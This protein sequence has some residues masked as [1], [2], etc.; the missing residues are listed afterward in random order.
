MNKKLIILMTSLVLFL[1]GCTSGGSSGTSGGSSGFNVDSYSGGD[2]AL[3]L[4]FAEGAPPERIRDQGRFPF[5]V[6]ILLEN[7][8]EYD[9]EE[10]TGYIALAGTDASV[11]GLTETSQIIPPL[12]GV[13]KISDD[14][15]A[16]GKQTVTFSGLRYTEN[17]GAGTATIPLQ[18]YA[19]YPYKTL[20]Q[21]SL[22]LSG[23][24]YQVYDSDV[25]ICDLESSR[26]IGSSGAPVSVQNLQQRPA[27]DSS[28]EFQF[29][30]VHSAT[31]NLGRL[32]RPDTTGENCFINDN[33]P[34]SAA[35]NNFEDYVYFEVSTGLE[36]T[37]NLNCVSEEEGVSPNT[38][39]AR[40]YQ[41]KAT[42]YCTQETTG[43]SE[44]QK[45]IKVDLSYDYLE[46]ISTSL[47]VEHAN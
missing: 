33:S 26:D 9:I 35:A 10:N 34:T 23:D 45:L 20:S 5:S 28:I 11:L 17:I 38:G 4:E 18:A 24:T 25:A 44:Q 47:L 2:S 6:R 37:L 41:N 32:F 30:I 15:R 42:V 43:L 22:C 46:R 13:K 21:S 3:T 1:A 12:R 16:G 19:C 36:N 27:G 39:Y 8:G 7:T 31:Q 40:L 14:V 29:D